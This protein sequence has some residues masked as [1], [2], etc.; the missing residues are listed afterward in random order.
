MCESQLT[1]GPEADVHEKS[2]GVAKS[3]VG[4]GVLLTQQ[5]VNDPLDDVVFD[6]HLGKRSSKTQFLYCTES[7]LSHITVFS[8]TVHQLKEGLDDGWSLREVAPPIG[9]RRYAVE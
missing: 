7:I 5:I 9:Q 3:V 2:K 6:H 8:L 4:K 1:Y